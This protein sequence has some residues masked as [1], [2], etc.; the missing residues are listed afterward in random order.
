MDD[1]RSHPTYLK[2]EEM[3]VAD[4]G[5]GPDS[6]GSERMLEHW[7]SRP[8]RCL[9]GYRPVDRLTEDAE[10]ILASFKA[11]LEQPLQG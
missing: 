2:L 3:R 7:L 5:M 4:W 1:F 10:M 6:W 8:N 11:D 9:G